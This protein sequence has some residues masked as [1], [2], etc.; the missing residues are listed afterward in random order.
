MALGGRE[1]RRVERKRAAKHEG[2]DY[3]AII[4]GTVAGEGDPPRMRIG[5]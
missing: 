4:Q 3:L 2:N 5:R 1:S